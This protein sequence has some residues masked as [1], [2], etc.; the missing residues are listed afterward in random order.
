MFYYVRLGP[1]EQGYASPYCLKTTGY[2]KPIPS[3]KY[4]L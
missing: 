4:E 3:S 1:G 2:C